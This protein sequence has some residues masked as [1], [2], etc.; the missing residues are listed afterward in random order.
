MKDVNWVD[1]E[2]KLSK[3]LSLESSV[4]HI[5]GNVYTVTC[6]GHFPVVLVMDMSISLV[7]LIATPTM[8]VCIL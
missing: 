7:S 5:S 4:L 8:P 3:H 1:P 6:V 2:R